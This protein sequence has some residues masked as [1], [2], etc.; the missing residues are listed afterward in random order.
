MNKIFFAILCFCPDT[1]TGFQINNWLLAGFWTAF[2][3]GR[4]TPEIVVAAGDMVSVRSRF[5]GTQTGPLGSLP[6]TGKRIEITFHDF[7]RMA[8]G[9]IAGHW[10]VFDAAG[11]MSQL[12]GN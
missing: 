6:A 3:D 7:Y 5:S 11:M 10:H 2:P 12:G 8:E 4:F 9:K 1:A